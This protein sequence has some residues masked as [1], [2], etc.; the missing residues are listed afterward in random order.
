MQPGNAGQQQQRRLSAFLPAAPSPPW[1]APPAPLGAGEGRGVGGGDGDQQPP[2]H[3]ALL[4]HARLSPTLHLGWGR[5]RVQ[6]CPSPLLCV[7]TRAGAVCP[8]HRLPAACRAPGLTNPRCAGAASTHRSGHEPQRCR[9]P[10][11]QGS[12]G[13]HCQERTSSPVAR[14]RCPPARVAPMARAP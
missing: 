10:P 8:C 9:M 11:A 5:R 2:P 6:R 13:C 12:G 1:A 4:L 14:R 7:G 3:F